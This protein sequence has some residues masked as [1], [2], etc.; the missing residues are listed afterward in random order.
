VEAYL[1]IFFGI[2]CVVGLL[3]GPNISAF[4]AERRRAR[5]S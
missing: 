4:I 1:V 5:G 2:G 3:F